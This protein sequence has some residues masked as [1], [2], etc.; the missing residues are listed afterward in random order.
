[1]GFALLALLFF[2]FLLFF[3]KDNYADPENRSGP[4]SSEVMPSS[5]IARTGIRLHATQRACTGIVR[6]PVLSTLGVGSL[7]KKTSGIVLQAD[8]QILAASYN[9]DCPAHS[10]FELR[11]VSLAF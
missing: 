3:V 9:L 8:V 2:L 5:G 7:P 10:V 4:F 6:I 1:M 11:D